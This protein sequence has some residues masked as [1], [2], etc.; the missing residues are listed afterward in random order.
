MGRREQA[1]TAAQEAV[2]IRRRLAETAPDAYLPDLADSLNNLA[3]FLA[4]AGR[5]EEALASAQEAITICRRL[6]ETAPTTY[7]PDLATVA[8]QP[9]HTSWPTWGAASR[10]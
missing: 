3:N 8:E 4:D 7:L 10:R 5:R 6:A 2:T 1:L 9:R